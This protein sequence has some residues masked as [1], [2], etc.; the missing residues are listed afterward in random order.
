MTTAEVIKHA[1]LGI[2]CRQLTLALGPACGSLR[3][4]HWLPVGDVCLPVRDASAATGWVELVH[5]DLAGLVDVTPGQ[6]L[7]VGRP[8]G[9]ALAA[10]D[11]R[12]VLLAGSDWRGSPLLHWLDRQAMP[13]PRGSLALWEIDRTAPFRPAPSRILLPGLPAGGLAAVP[14]CEGHGLPSRVTSHRQAR[15]GCS[16]ERLESLAVEW[17]AHHPGRPFRLLIAGDAAFAA[18]LQAAT[19]A[20]NVTVERAAAV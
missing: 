15:P 17:L 16:T 9:R 1:P 5:P 11:D 19:D 12:P 18:R 6:A 7:R 14:D 2:G 20:P 4:G 10:A 8:R 13:L 3:P